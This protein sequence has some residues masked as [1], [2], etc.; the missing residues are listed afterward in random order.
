MPIGQSV[1]ALKLA[2][3]F[4]PIPTRGRK[5][6]ALPPSRRRCSESVR[7]WRFQ[8]ADVTGAH[9]ELLEPVES[10]SRFLRTCSFLFGMEFGE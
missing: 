6:G 8:Q 1:G 10:G 9:S 3:H 4:R 5:R 7:T 2:S